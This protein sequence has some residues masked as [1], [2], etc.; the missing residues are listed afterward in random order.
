MIQYSVYKICCLLM[1]ISELEHTHLSS[2]LPEV[3]ASL[4]LKKKKKKAAVLFMLIQNNHCPENKEHGQAADEFS[5]W[6]HSTW[7]YLFLF[8]LPKSQQVENLVVCCTS[9]MLKY[10]PK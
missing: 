6:T 5:E 3:S 9:I 4:Q 10:M 2:Y 1:G 8:L 7:I